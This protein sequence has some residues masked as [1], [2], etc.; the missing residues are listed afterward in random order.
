[1]FC[2]TEPGSLK[3]LETVVRDRPTKAEKSSIVLIVF[4]IHGPLFEPAVSTFYVSHPFAQ[5]RR[6]FLADAQTIG[7]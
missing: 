4:A 3:Y 7:P 2:L 6:V 5:S 1:V